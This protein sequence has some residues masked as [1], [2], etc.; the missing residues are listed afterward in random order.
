MLDLFKFLL[1]LEKGLLLEVVLEIASNRLI[2]PNSEGRGKEEH[3]M[4]FCLRQWP[5]YPA[6]ILLLSLLLDLFYLFLQ[7]GI[8]ALHLRKHGFHLQVALQA[9]LFG[10]HRTRIP[11]RK[12]SPQAGRLHHIEVREFTQFKV[13]SYH[14]R[15]CFFHWGFDS[16][17]AVLAGSLSYGAIIPFQSLECR[18]RL[19][20]R[21]RWSHT[22]PESVMS[23]I[24]AWKRSNLWLQFHVILYDWH[25]L[26]RLASSLLLALLFR[27]QGSFDKCIFFSSNL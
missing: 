1:K 10:N 3:N 7:L 24:L 22:R 19:W 17:I 8:M 27:I 5:R 6:D 18:M 4:Q 23:V 11:H 13:S 15:S 21:R 2:S 26:F 16:K 20:E 9:L 14:S 12:H 25:R